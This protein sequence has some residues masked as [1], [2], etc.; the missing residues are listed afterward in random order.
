MTDQDQI[1]TATGR[2]WQHDSGWVLLT[3]PPE[4]SEELTATADLGPGWG[5][6]PVTVSLG[7]LTW[8]T[9]AWPG[10]D[11]HLL[12]VKSSIRKRAGLTPGE[13]VTVR[14]AIDHA[15]LRHR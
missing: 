11:G 7:D 8:S 12:P 1:S 14:I 13:E 6:V 5:M 10:Q 15:R 9:S 4:L 3:L 2:L